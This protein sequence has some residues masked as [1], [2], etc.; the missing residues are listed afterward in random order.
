MFSLVFR[1]LF[2]NWRNFLVWAFA[3]TLIYSAYFSLVDD[4]PMWVNLVVSTITVVV[5]FTLIYLLIYI[6]VGLWFAVFWFLLFLLHC[7]VYH[8]QKWWW[9]K[10]NQRIPK[11]L[12]PTFHL[13]ERIWLAYVGKG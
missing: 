7:Y 11:R 2:G 3:F 5:L 8:G 4:D 6:F 9:V 12:E 10:G 1:R 13:L